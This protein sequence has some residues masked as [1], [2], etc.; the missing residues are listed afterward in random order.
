MLRAKPHLSPLESR[1]QLLIAESEINRIQ[2]LREWQTMGQGAY[3]LVDRAKSISSIASAAGLFVAGL[4]GLWRRKV[5]PAS[6]KPSWFQTVLKGAQLAG[7]IW[8]AFRARRHQVGPNEPDRS[9][10]RR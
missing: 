4:A 9:T 6:V 3:G 1:K 10:L 7:P 5:T 2:L 8:L